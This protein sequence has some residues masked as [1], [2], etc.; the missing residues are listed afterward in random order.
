MTPPNEPAQAALRLAERLIQLLDRGGFTATYKYAVLIG[1]IDLCMEQTGATGLP[2]DAITTWQLAEKVI[3]LYWPQCAPFDGEGRVLRQNA[4]KYAPSKAAPVA[5]KRDTQAEIVRSIT[6]F[7][8]VA[9]ENPAASLPLSRAR[10]NRP[11]AYEQLVREVEWKLIEMPLPRLQYVGR[12]EDRF[13]YEYAFSRDIKRRE[14]SRYQQDRGRVPR[15]FDNRLLLKPGVGAALVGLNGVLRPLIHRN[16]ALMVASVNGLPGSPLED[17]LFGADRISLLPVRPH[18]RDLQDGR[19]F[20]CSKGLPPTCHVDHFIPWSR[21][22]DNS[23]D[24]LVAAHE[25]CNGKK[26]DFLAAAEHVERWR[27]R[28]ATKAK[29][30][31]EIARLETWESRPDRTVGVARAIYRALPDDARLWR[32]GQEFI[33]IERPRIAAALSV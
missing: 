30:L 23:I 28:S 5:D 14:V 6:R 20:Y 3:E 33:V 10:A 9:A 17:F 25:D 31:A 15:T 4:S 32:A 18:L 22:A 1:L 12:Q 26:R 27:D 7:R 29:T 11:E 24:N 13:L 8:Q 2:P 19:C 21:H 16:W